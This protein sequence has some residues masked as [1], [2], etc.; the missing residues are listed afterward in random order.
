MA[1]NPLVVLF[2]PSLY[3]VGAL[4]SLLQFQVLIALIGKGVLELKKIPSLSSLLPFVVG[5]NDYLV[6]VFGPAQKFVPQP[7]HVL[8]VA[9]MMAVIIHTERMRR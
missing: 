8:L 4:F 6:K 5:L 7:T 3:I 9:L 2:L 1:T